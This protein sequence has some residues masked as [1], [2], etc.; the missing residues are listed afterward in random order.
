VDLSQLVEDVVKACGPAAGFRIL[1]T[2]DHHN[3]RAVFR[4]EGLLSLRLSVNVVVNTGDLCGIGGPIERLILGRFFRPIAPTVFAPGNHDSKATINEMRR[5][6][7][8]VLDL[9][10]FAEVGGVRFWGYRDPNHSRMLF[11]PRYQ[12]ALCRAIARRLEPG[13]AETA[14]PF[15]AVV[16]HESMVPDPVP[17]VCPLILCGHF[18][19]SR[20]RR[21]RS[22]TLIVRTGAS[23]GRNGHF[24][25]ALRF[26]V[27]DVD[28]A[29]FTPIA[30]WVFEAE[31]H[32][33]RIQRPA[34]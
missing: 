14:T 4:L 23:G 16:H 33:L 31:D 17:K 7:A 22:G 6:G 25:R 27:I 24:S 13:L 32:D 28:A 12:S 3:R 19:S 21:R 8:V 29:T 15:V 1:H 11:G 18:H 34:V 26:S 10:T 9:P 20:I 5:L 30:V 2:T